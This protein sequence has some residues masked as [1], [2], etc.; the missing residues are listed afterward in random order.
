MTDSP[1]APRPAVRTAVRA[2]KDRGAAGSRTVFERMFEHGTSRPDPHA[3]VKTGTGRAPSVRRSG[4][5]EP[6]AGSAAC[7]RPSTPGWPQVARLLSDAGRT[8]EIRVLPDDVRTAAAAAAALG[9]P[10][11]AIVNSLVFAVDGGRRA[12]PLLVLTSGAH[13]VDETT[14][15]GLLGVAGISPG[16]RRLRPQAHR[17]GH[18][19]RRADRAPR[20]DR[21]PRRR[22]ARPA[23]RRSGPPPDTRSTVFPTSYDEL[24]RLTAGTAAEVGSGPTD[25]TALGVGGTE[26]LAP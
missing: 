9:V 5:P 17:P 18:R 14:V 8:G 15:A 7:P 20:A 25:A 13:R 4:P 21:H 10:V 22:R 24:L 12:R 1:S 2:G 19:R 16:R 26:A 23:R 3:G 6:V 11:G